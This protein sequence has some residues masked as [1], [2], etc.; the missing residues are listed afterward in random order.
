ME[1]DVLTAYCGTNPGAK[2]GIS[3]PETC[4]PCD[5]CEAY[6]TAWAETPDAA[7]RI[8]ALRPEEAPE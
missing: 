5:E 7:R 1:A 3:H 6:L 4:G 8:A 2:V